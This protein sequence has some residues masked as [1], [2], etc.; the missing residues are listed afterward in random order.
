MAKKH[1]TRYEALSLGGPFALTHS[2]IPTPGPHEVLVGIKAIGL[3]GFDYKQLDY[4]LFVKSWPV[5]LGGEAAGI[6]EAIGTEVDGF[7]VGDEVVA[8]CSSAYGKSAAFQTHVVLPTN[9]LALKPSSLSFKEGA[10]L[11]KS[12]ITASCAVFKDLSIPLPFLGTNH[13]PEGPYAPL[14]ILV[15]GGSSSVGASAIQILRL[16]LPTATI[17]TTSSPRHHERLRELG[18]SEAFDYHGSEL[19]HLIRQ[20]TPNGAGV[21]VILDAV[22]AVAL[23][24]SLFSLFAPKPDGVN[25][26]AEI[27]TGRNVAPTSIPASI[28]HLPVMGASVLTVP[29]GGELMGALGGLLEKRKFRNPAEIVVVGS[30][31][32]SLAG[33]LQKL[34]LGV[35]GEKYVVTI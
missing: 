2:D 20:A 5:V 33:G 12:Y 1:S 13:T 30:G 25:K 27:I 10:A 3:N 21:E 31:L 8:Y 22:N 16:A 35:S 24:P 14:T 11:P 6:V 18:A 26:F 34:K 15:L 17:L 29:A 28:T 7:K 23:T 9:L 32:E 4:G 19:I